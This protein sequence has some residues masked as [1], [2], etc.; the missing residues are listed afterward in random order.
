MKDPEEVNLS[1]EDGA[2]L[3]ERLENNALTTHDRHI[4][5]E[6]ITFHFSQTLAEALDLRETR[7]TAPVGVASSKR[8]KH[9][10]A[11]RS[12][13][14]RPATTALIEIVH[15]KPNMYGINR[16]NWSYQSLA[17]AYEKQY[18]QRMSTATVR[19]LLQEVGFHWKKS[20]KV[21][22]S[23]DPHYREKVELLLSTLQSLQADEMFFFI[24]DPIKS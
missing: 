9:K 21:L 15:H 12:D 8:A 22:T 7:F 4:L 18:S 11:M 17:D 10:K 19:R 2:A 16:S 23:P 3:I 6:L 20:R 24:N 13:K 1:R 5:K 14:I